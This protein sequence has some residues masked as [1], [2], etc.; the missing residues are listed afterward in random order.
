MPF[1]QTDMQKVQRHML[2]TGFRVDC[3]ACG[4]N[5]WSFDEVVAVPGFSASGAIVVSGP[6]MPMLQVVCMRCGY[7]MHFAAKL[8]GLVP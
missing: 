5:N 1:S 8:I 4:A 2:I 3:Q 7:V 6:T